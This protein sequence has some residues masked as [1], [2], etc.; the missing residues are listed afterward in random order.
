MSKLRVAGIGA[1][2]FSQ[3]HMAGWRA[4]ADVDLVGWCDRDRARADA[5]ASTHSVATFT[6][7][8]DMLESARCSSSSSPLRWP[9]YR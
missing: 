3:F 4:I 9:A 8:A 7:L 6:S 2:Y 1:G 5:V